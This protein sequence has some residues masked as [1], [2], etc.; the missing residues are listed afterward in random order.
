MQY[1]LPL[2]ADTRLAR[3]HGLLLARFGPVPECYRLDPVSQL[4]FAMLS[5]R[6]RDAVAMEVFAAL[7]RRMG[8]WERLAETAASELEGMIAGVTFAERKARQIPAALREIAARRGRLDLEFL[9]GWP[10]EEG[11]VWLESLTGV[12]PKTSMAVLGLSTL[13]R[14]ALMVDTAHNRVAGRLGLV[15][16]RADIAHAT[17]LL[18]RQLPAAWTADDTETHHFLMQGLGRSHCRHRRPVCA[19]C[20]LCRLCQAVP[21]GR[22]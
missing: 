3:V 17:R 9:A 15:P 1:T 22:A 13:R 7:V 12:G 19:D 14:R 5:G 6:T 10:V 2:V 20:P 8:A 18:N 21:E 16:V 11:R 4:V